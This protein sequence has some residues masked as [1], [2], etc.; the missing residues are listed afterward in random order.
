MMCIGMRELTHYSMHS[1]Q[2]MQLPSVMPTLVSALA[3]FTSML[4]AALEVRQTLLT[5]VKLVLMLTVWATQ[6]MPE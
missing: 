3:Q 1:L 4:L 5:A 2:Q 6:W